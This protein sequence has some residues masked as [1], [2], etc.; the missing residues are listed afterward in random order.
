MGWG[1]VGWVLLSRRSSETSKLASW[2]TNNLSAA[3]SRFLAHNSAVAYSVSGSTT[4]F[5]PQIVVALV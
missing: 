1:G 4:V 2:A 3:A 5:N